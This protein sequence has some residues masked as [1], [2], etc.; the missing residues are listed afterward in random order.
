MTRLTENTMP[1]S[2]IIPVATAAKNDWTEAVETP[3]A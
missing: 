1:V 2:A 3:P